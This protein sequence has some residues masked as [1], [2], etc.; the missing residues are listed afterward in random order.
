MN[1]RDTIGGYP[2]NGATFVVKRHI[3]G[4]EGA[5]KLGKMVKV[6]NFRS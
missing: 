4:A 6:T 5:V 1:I 3:F 2:Q